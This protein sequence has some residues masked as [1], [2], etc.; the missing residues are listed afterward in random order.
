[1]RDRLLRS[2]EPL[3]ILGILLLAT[4]LRLEVIGIR[5]LW[6]DEA[7]SLDAARRSVSD[8]LVFLRDTEPHPPGYYLLLSLWRRLVGE[9]LARLRALSVVFGLGAVL[10][11]WRM[12][13]AVFA[14]AI[15]IAGAALVAVNPFQI[16]ASNELRMYM[17][18]ECASLAATWALWRADRASRPTGWA[19]TYGAAMALAAYASYYAALLAGAHAVW[20][21]VTA[22][23]WRRA[24]RIALPAAAGALVV[25][26]PWLAVVAGGTLPP[27][28]VGQWRQALWPS[29][30]PEI[31]AAQT[32]GG[33]VFDAA[34]YFTLRGL[35][36]QYYGI[37][38]FPFLALATAGLSALGRI[39]RPGR[40]LVLLS[41]T[42]PLGV[43]V[44]GSLATG[45]VAAYAYHLNFLQPFMALVVGAGVVR[46]RDEV[47][48]APRAVVIVGAALIVAAFIA[49]AVDNL[50][51]NPAYQA[52]RYDQ[53]ARFVRTQYRPGDAV[54]F[55]P[56]G[57]YR[58]FGF[59]F[60]PPG[61]RLGVPV[62]AQ[63]FNREAL[64]KP[65]AQLAAQLGPQ[66]TRV[67]LVYT[68]PLPEGTLEDL[69]LAIEARGYRRTAISDFRGVFVGLLVRPAR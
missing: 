19:T 4:S 2:W 51:T 42:V 57:T 8:L 17:P 21:V 3:A 5:G 7:F 60:A 24:A 29:Y 22:R 61:K 13:R 39:D 23:P 56:L 20:L 67:W 62:T 69:L 10:L 43:V 35:S 49:P 30:V 6:Q 68:L 50:Q 16:F 12:G 47:A 65:I 41:W 27:V 34:T 32:F 40:S 64:R 38:L 55:I 46:L 25:Y 48:A 53:A 58:G 11:T 59:Y 15:G 14:P 26:S 1:M 9:D 37:L 66:D 54:V 33:Y 45:Y 31:L 18:L 36:V 63:T 28:Y 52:Y 44:A